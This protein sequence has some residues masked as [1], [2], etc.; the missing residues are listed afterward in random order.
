MEVM[1]IDGLDDF[2]MR[3]KRQDAFWDC[4]VL[5]RPCVHLTIP[6]TKAGYPA[7][8]GNHG[9]FY[10]RWMDVEYQAENALA[11]VKNTIYMGD[12]LPRQ[13]PNLGPD[14]FPALY[15]GEMVFE[16]STSFINPFLPSWAEADRLVWSREH[17][18]WKKMEELYDAFLEAGK[19]TFYVG[20]PDLHPGADCLVGLRG[21][22]AMAIDLFDEPEAVK[23][24]LKMVTK[25]F[26]EVY[27]HYYKKLT[28]S[29]QTCTG[30]PEIV[31]TRKWHVPSCDFSYM[32]GPEQFDEF[33]LDGL[34]QECDFFEASLHHLD[35]VGCLNHLD[36][37]LEIESLNAVQ[38]VW[39]AGKGT[40]L[41]WIDVF[42]KIQAAGKGIQLLEVRP[43]QLDSIIETLR[44]EGVWMKITGVESEAAGNALLKKVSHWV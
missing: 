1:P 14:F 11:T 13:C 24:M 27:D 44:P 17:P 34:R 15:G 9:S 16:D 7:P 40:A 42:K 31:S 25:D 18:Y 22:Q 43:D 41:N 28:A 20:W 26:F 5:D 23:T 30:W 35:G 6:R 19:N 12:A 38:W 37:L 21:P 29:G 32:I 39:G 36:S 33:F 10:D 3:L 8:A 4:A 2:E